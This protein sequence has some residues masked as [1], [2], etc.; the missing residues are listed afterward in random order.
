MSSYD[1]PDSIT[2][3]FRNGEASYSII[4][5]S[6]SMDNIESLQYFLDQ[7]GVGSEYIDEHLDT[8]VV[9]MHPDFDYKLAIHSGGLGDF[10]SHGFD[11]EVLQ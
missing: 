6:H 11:V 9:L 3:M 2:D 1:I 7:V 4:D 5:Y 10:Y 8:M